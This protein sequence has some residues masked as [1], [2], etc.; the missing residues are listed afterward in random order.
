MK[1]GL[2]CMR[3]GRGMKKG[4]VGIKSLEKL[5]QKEINIKLLEASL[6]NID[7]TLDCLEWVRKH[8]GGL[9]RISSSLIPYNEFWKWEEY[10]EILKKLD[11][12][13]K[14]AKKNNIRLIMHPDQFTVINSES[15][16]VVKNS[17]TILNH[18]NKLSRLTGVEDLIIHTGSTKGDYKERFIKNI[19]LLD[20]E[21]REKLILENCHYVGIEDVIDICQKTGIRPCLDF[22]HDRIKPSSKS[23][24]S[25]IDDVVRLS[26]DRTPLGHISSPAGT[27]PK[28]Y[29]SHSEY[30]SQEDLRRFERYF[31][32]FDMEIE[33]KGKEKAVKR[34]IDYFNTK[35]NSKIK[36]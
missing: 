32:I 5:S 10:T 4:V 35:K 1:I 27:A 20:N 2:V 30:I 23:I 28:D 26:K 25:Y 11:I 22:H 3:K 15:E 12:V 8:E 29:K 9:F 13:K 14:F 7:Y 17:I 19:K 31:E 18:H 33:A 36:L 21:V 34:V 24:E 16:E 6:F